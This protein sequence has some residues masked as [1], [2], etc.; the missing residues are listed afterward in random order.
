MRLLENF[1]ERAV[2][3]S[4]DASTKERLVDLAVSTYEG[5]ATFEA[6]IAKAMTAL[7]VSPRFIFRDLRPELMDDSDYPQVDEYSLA[8]RLSYFLWSTMPDEHLMQLSREHRLR[9]NYDA[10]VQRMLN[11]DKAK[12]FTENFVGQWLKARSIESIPIN[13]RAVNDR[14]T[15]PDP[16]ADAR[17]K[18]FFE[19]VR[20]EKKT[21]EE[22]KEF[23][24]LGQSVRRGG[25]GGR[26]SGID[27]T[28][29]VRRA[30]RRET[31]MLFEYVFRENRSL[32]E[33]V[34]CDYTF[35]NQT[36]ANHYQ[37]SGV[38]GDQMRLVQLPADSLRGGLLT[39]GTIL[40]VTSNPDRTSPVKRGLF[41]LENLLGAP[42]PAAPPRRRRA[43]TGR[44]HRPARRAAPIPASPRRAPPRARRT[45]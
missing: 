12:A 11:D 43:P 30:M 6:G 19:L 26:G 35:L 16:E 36:L 17:R 1:A 10:Q 34:D 14:E 7:L 18:R 22:Q 31:E 5:G 9:E 38:E 44:A 24:Q 13:A 28:P 27:L 23:D 32:L 15:A 8:S 45:T 4:V 3:R 21:E 40:A 41:V 29:D 42:P 33:L 20:I 37:I 25:R 2:R 39:Q